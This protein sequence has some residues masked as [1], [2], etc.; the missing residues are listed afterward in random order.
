[1]NIHHFLLVEELSHKLFNRSTAFD[2]K[3]IFPKVFDV[4]TRQYLRFG[5]TGVSYILRKRSL[6]F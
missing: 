6:P 4:L 1:M 3:A 5:Y 2:T